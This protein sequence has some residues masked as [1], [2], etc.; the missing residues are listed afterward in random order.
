MLPDI[1]SKHNYNN[2]NKLVITL[3]LACVKVIGG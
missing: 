1:H 2:I 3:I